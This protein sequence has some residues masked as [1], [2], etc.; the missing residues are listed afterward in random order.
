MKIAGKVLV[1]L[2]I[3]LVGA[4][5]L[6]VTLHR[7]RATVAGDEAQPVEISGSLEAE[8][9]DV[10][11]KIPGRV[12]QMLVDEGD[13]VT[14]GQ[15]IAVMEA[16]N[17]EAKANLA[18]AA[19]AA[20][21]F[22]YEKARNGAR[23]Q[24]LEQAREMMAQAKAGFDLAQS[25]YNRLSLLY[26]EGVLAQQKLDVAGTELEVARARYNA[27]KEQYDL[28]REGAQKEDVESA[29]ALVRQAQ[30]ASDEVQTYLNDAKVKAPIGGTVTMKAV[31]GGELVSTGMPIV[32]ISDL[33]DIHVEVKVRETALGQFRLGQIVPVKVLGVPGKVYRGKVYNIGAKPSYAT[34]RAYQEKGE[35]DLVAFGV[36]IKLD[37]SDL[38]LRPGMTALISLAPR[39]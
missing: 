15:V 2:F 25:T 29:A 24:Q 16:D 23:P 3:V 32:T 9:T 28:V 6:F 8:E 20:A 38:K 22:Q 26:K 12:A 21:T 19:L 4:A 7:S 18:K 14:A 10:N 33:R 1:G 13:E 17:I 5:L 35:K 30:A 37:N 27:A 39:K 31:T 36:K 11:V 34:E